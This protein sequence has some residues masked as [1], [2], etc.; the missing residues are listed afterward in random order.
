MIPIVPKVRWQTASRTVRLAV[1]ASVRWHLSLSGYSGTVRDA[2]DSPRRVECLK[3]GAELRPVVLL[4]FLAGREQVDTEKG[5]VRIL[6][7]IHFPVVGLAPGWDSGRDSGSVVGPVPDL[8]TPES[9]S[10]PG[11]LAGWPPVVGRVALL[12]GR[13]YV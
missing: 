6:H 13:S 4:V 11:L 9:G 5:S 8:P 7:E 2:A 3:L 10:V 1:A 12:V